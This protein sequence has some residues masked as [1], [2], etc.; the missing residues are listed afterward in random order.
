MTKPSPF[1]TQCTA[2]AKR[3]GERCRS[4][5]VGGGVCFKHGGA[6]PQVK[7]K[8]LARVATMELAAEAR[9]MG[10]TLP[11]SSPAQM[12][13]DAARSTHRVVALLQM[14][15]GDAPNPAELEQLG[16]W[17]DRLGRAAAL[18]V[19][20]KAD[21]LAIAQAARVA[22]GQARVMFRAL[23]GVVSR[24]GLTDEQR[25]RVPD[26]LRAALAALGLSAPGED[27]LPAPRPAQARTAPRA[28]IEGRVQ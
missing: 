11:D 8:R 15:A 28:A 2:T 1:S 27:A 21:E 16:P 12:L 6:A 5:V 7:A 20:S 10:E 14:R 24:L 3:T 26:A 17:L 18:V 23:E 13:L 22:D 9:A 19:S 4:L 25:A